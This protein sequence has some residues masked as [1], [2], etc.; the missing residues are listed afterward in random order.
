[1]V[2]ISSASDMLE[3]PTGPT[4]TSGELETPR[5]PIRTVYYQ[6]WLEVGAD[7]ANQPWTWMLVDQVVQRCGHRACE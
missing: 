6:L 4:M 2:T 5:P 1:M 7:R 3:L